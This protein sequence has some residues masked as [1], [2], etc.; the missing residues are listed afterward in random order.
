MGTILLLLITGLT[1]I[2]SFHG[3]RGIVF[4]NAEKI[5]NSFGIFI[6]LFGKVQEGIAHNGVKLSVMSDS[7]LE[8]ITNG[9][10]IHFFDLHTSDYDITKEVRGIQIG[11]TN[12]AK[13]YG[14]QIGLY[15]SSNGRKSFLVNFDFRKF[16]KN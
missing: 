7:E 11:L 15:N 12:I 1:L 5:K 16:T 4:L 8:G 6:A 9:L 13:V 2:G 3:V 14:I 10:D